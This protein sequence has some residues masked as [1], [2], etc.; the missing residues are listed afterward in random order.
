MDWEAIGAVLV[1]VAI[2]VI[3]AL[4]DCII[5]YIERPKN[6]LQRYVPATNHRQVTVR[7][8]ADTSA[9]RPTRL[10]NRQRES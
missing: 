10:G 9:E 1:L 3:G 7:R 4:V 8:A 2:F 6:Q 5:S